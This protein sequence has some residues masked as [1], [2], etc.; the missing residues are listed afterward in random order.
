MPGVD[1]ARPAR[2]R[3]RRRSDDV[4]PLG[5][6]DAFDFG[7]GI[8]GIGNGGRA[9]DRLLVP[10]GRTTRPRSPAADQT[11]GRPGR[12]RSLWYLIED[13]NDPAPDEL[14]LQR[15]GDRGA[16]RAVRGQGRLAYAD[17]GTRSAGRGR[18][19]SR[20]PTPRPTPTGRTTV[21][22]PTG[23]QLLRADPARA[24]SR[25]TTRSRLHRQ[26]C[27]LPRRLR[28]DHRRHRRGRQDHRRQGGR[29]GSSPVR[30]KDEDRRPQGAMRPDRIN[31][32]P[33]KDRLD[34]LAQGQAP[35][36]APASA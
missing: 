10:E 16:R 6:T 19:R 24:R 35:G 34:R 29:S 7:L 18:R 23:R 30:G 9:G 33:G 25:P 20:A 5:I 13:F 4:S 2:Q 31:C 11:D 12:R 22:V 3:R 26:R 14:E 28:D 15:A 27:G 21:T 32:G 8:C 1:G 17:D 36:T